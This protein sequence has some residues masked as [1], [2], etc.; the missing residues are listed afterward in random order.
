MVYTI[1]STKMKVQKKKKKK[2]KKPM[3]SYID[4]KML[5]ANGSFIPGNHYRLST[6]CKNL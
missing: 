1:K 2:K 3:E 5:I 6:H 4:C